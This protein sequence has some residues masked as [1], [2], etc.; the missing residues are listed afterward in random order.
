MFLSH[1]WAILA[2]FWGHF[3]PFWG[4]FLGHFGVILGGK[5]GLFCAHQ[6]GTLGCDK[7]CAGFSEEN[8][9][10]QAE[11]LP[12]T[13]DFWCFWVDFD[14]NRGFTPLLLKNGRFWTISGRFQVKKRFKWVLR[15]SGLVLGNFFL[16]AIRHLSTIRP[17][18]V[19]PPS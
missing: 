12:K 2:P 11:K 19:L 4:S 1:F 6:G 16:L 8:P 5:N 9:L 15:P 14:Q 17:G 18:I 10:R 7:I 3:C 13:D